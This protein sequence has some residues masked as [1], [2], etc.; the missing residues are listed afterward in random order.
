MSSCTECG[1]DWDATPAELPGQLSVIPHRAAAPL[2]TFLAGEDPARLV[3]ARPSAEVWSALEYAAHT[4]DALSFYTGR[5]ERVLAADRPKLAP[6]DADAQCAKQRYNEQEVTRVLEELRAVTDR[7]VGRLVVLDDDGWRRA[8]IGGDGGERTVLQL[9][10]RAAHEGRHHLLD[11][12]RVLR[13][14]RGR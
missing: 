1:Y 7:L 5:I 14:L 13:K 3:R 12:G 6:F 11:I 8:G 4:R 10:R 9:A 2:T